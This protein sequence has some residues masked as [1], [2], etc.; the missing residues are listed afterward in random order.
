MSPARAVQ[1]VSRAP[2]TRPSDLQWR[3]DRMLSAGREA[4]GLVFLRPHDSRKTL[5]LARVLS[6]GTTP[7]FSRCGPRKDA[8]ETEQTAASS[9]PRGRTHAG[10]ASV[11]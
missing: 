5:L 11:D 2:S 6:R 10:A 9:T 3:R 8:R 7:H 1:R 4:W